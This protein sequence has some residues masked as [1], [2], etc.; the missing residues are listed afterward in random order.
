[1]SYCTQGSSP[2][3]KM[4][5]KQLPWA[6]IICKYLEGFYNRWRISLINKY[7]RR[8]H[9]EGSSRPRSM[10]KLWSLHLIV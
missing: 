4:T 10:H 6:I 2:L 3:S 9:I 8:N 1:M 5:K 7:G